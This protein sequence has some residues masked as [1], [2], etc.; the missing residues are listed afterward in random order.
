MRQ[1]THVEVDVRQTGVAG[2]EEQSESDEQPVGAATHWPL[3]QT[4]LAGQSTSVT[5]VVLAVWH[6]PLTHCWPLGQ[7]A[8]DVQIV[9]GGVTHFW[10]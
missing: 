10:S 8:L 4:S 2:V 1:A 3:V 5:Q 9:G 7:L 6:A